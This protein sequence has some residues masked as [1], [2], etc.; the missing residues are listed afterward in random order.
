MTNLKKDLNRNAPF[1]VYSEKTR[2]SYWWH[3]ADYSNFCKKH[4]QQTGVEELRTQLCLNSKM[5]VAGF[6][7]W[8]INFIGS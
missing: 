7:F 8:I 5:L 2:K 1:V 3:I 6:S 4:P